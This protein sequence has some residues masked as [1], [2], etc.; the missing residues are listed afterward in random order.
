M[1]DER[2]LGQVMQVSPMAKG[3]VVMP[4]AAFSIRS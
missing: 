2:A 3:E 4:A 1:T